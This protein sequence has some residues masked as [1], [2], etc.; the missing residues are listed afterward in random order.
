MQELFILVGLLVALLA[1]GCP[2]A[3][4]MLIAS[5][6]YLLTSSLPL[7]QLTQKVA[8][9]VDS[10]PLLAI[11][12]FL[13]AG[14]LMNT[15]GVTDRIFGF[16]RQVLV[17]ATYHGGPFAATSTV[18]AS[19]ISRANVRRRVADAGGLGK[20]EIKACARPA[21]RNTPSASAITGGLAV[22]GPRHPAVEHHFINCFPYTRKSSAAC[23]SPRPSG[24]L[25]A[26]P[27]DDPHLLPGPHGR[28]C[29]PRPAAGEP[30][31]E[32]VAAPFRGASA[33]AAPVIPCRDHLGHL[34]GRPGRGY[35]VLFRTATCELH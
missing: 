12:M 24:L 6:V 20:V 18:V 33:A 32:G 35:S 8:A 3:F 31:V 28:L 27:D 21:L 30:F 7:L 14:G 10:F 13:L 2:V 5:V 26:L 17:R 11:P 29:C 15:M 19:V 4:A 1:I 23:S 34:H 22:I 16:G 25:M 9:G